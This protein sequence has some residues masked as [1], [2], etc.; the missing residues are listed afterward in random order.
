VKN[1]AGTRLGSCDCDAGIEKARAPPSKTIAR[2][3]GQVD[4]P[5]CNVMV[6][7]ITAQIASVT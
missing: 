4:R 3:I 7:I 6:N 2:K 1:S 5:P